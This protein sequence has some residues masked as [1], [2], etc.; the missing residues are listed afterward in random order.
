MREKNKE[1]GNRRKEEGKVIRVYITMRVHTLTSLEDDS[2]RRIF[3]HFTY[4]FSYVTS[5][6]QHTTNC[7]LLN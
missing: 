5:C 4:W 2:L 1:D 3:P 6:L 7:L